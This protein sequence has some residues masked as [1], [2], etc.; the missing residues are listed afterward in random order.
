MYQQ[1]P[2]VSL[3]SFEETDTLLVEGVRYQLCGVVDHQGEDWDDGHW[4]NYT[5][6]EG[7]WYRCSDES[8]EESSFNEIFSLDN[9]MFAFQKI[10]TEEVIARPNL[11]KKAQVVCRGCSRTFK[12]I[13]THLNSSN[14]CRRLYEEREGKD[15]S[16]VASKRK[17]VEETVNEPPRKVRVTVASNDTG[18]GDDN[19]DEGEVDEFQKEEDYFL[20]NDSAA[21]FQFNHH[22]VTVFA[23]DYPEMKINGE[24]LTVAPGEGNDLSYIGVIIFNLIIYR[25]VSNK[26]SSRSRVGCSHSSSFGP[27]CREQHEQA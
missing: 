25:K 11:E 1:D 13:K 6:H 5:K 16:G 22:S 27:F 4:L 21:K 8:I 23:H 20:K 18:Q 7:K 24:T 3:K 26:H 14:D 9:Y 15:S 19:N 12:R 2:S 17:M 10:E